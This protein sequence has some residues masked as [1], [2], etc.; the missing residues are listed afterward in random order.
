MNAQQLPTKYTGIWSESKDNC[1]NDVVVNI[2]PTLISTFSLTEEIMS[3]KIISENE[4]LVSFITFNGEENITISWKL[5][6]DNNNLKVI[7]NEETRNYIKCPDNLVQKS[8]PR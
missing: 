3:V 8:I 2:S 7:E 5:I 4:C 1:K 6:L